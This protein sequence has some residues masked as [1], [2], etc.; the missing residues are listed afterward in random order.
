MPPNPPS[1]DNGDGRLDNSERLSDNSDGR[2]DDSERLCDNSD[3]RLGDSE[4]LSDNGDGRLDDSER[5]SDNGDGP[6][7]NRER[8]S[9]NSDGR[10]DGSERLSDNGDG[11]LD[12]S[13]R[14][15]DNGDGRLDNGER[16]P[17]DDER[18]VALPERSAVPR[19]GSAVMQAR[20][21]RVP[22]HCAQQKRPARRQ[23]CSEKDGSIRLYAALTQ[24]AAAGSAAILAARS[25]LSTGPAGSRRSQRSFHRSSGAAQLHEELPG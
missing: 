10:L 19:Q 24:V 22:L 23:R 21:I 25:T 6:L 1:P 4:R 8:L 16:A 13:E 2:L 18:F 5:L 14:L 7:D 3:G 17:G 15:S 20:S 9:D 11:R 12:D